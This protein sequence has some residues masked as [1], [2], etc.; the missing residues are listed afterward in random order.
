M[1]YT[2]FDNI[3]V[4][5]EWGFESVRSVEQGTHGYHRYP[6]KFLPNVVK[7]L[8]DDFALKG[9]M[10]ADPFAGCGTTLVEAKA[11]GYESRGVDINPVA[12]L[13]T[14]VKTI[15]IVPELLNEYYSILTKR[16]VS[17]QEDDFIGLKKHERIDYW[18]RPQEKYQIAFIYQEIL[19]IDDNA[20]KD[21][22]LVSLSH[23]LKSCSRWLQ[24]S[25]KPQIDKNKNISSPFGAFQKHTQMMM[26]KNEEF[27]LH[28]KSND[29]LNTF[30]EIQLGDAR[31]T[32]W[33]N[34]SVG[35]IITS[36]PYVTSY[37]YADIHQLT[38]YWF[39]YF[40]D[41]KD[42]RQRFIGTSYSNKEKQ[43]VSSGLGQKI[44]DDLAKKSSKIS[45]DV[46]NYFNDMELVAKEMYRVLQ[47]QG[48][49]CI[50][51]GNTKVKDV[52]IKS[53]EVF[54]NLLHHAGFKKK[55]FIKRSIPHKLMPT[56]RNTKN[57]KFTKVTDPDSKKVYP[58]EYII[59]VKK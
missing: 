44:V 26:Q 14:S 34:E 4:D 58:N 48:I 54:W 40:S 31:N 11:H 43:K 7:K 3:Q 46:A 51:I 42:F 19:K 35:T 41:L 39:D 6:A 56:I 47:P 21:F 10:I 5:T 16:F 18:F 36:P 17:Y 30:C 37:E 33:A 13:I 55:K 25:T 12:T 38:G 27:F 29:R 23:I 9:A 15:P 8:I 52:D 49:A 45:K 59:I 57:G 20:I 2:N 32:G 28:L 22:F 24:S 53:A 50:V 1:R